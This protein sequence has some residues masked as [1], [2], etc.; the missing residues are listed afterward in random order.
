[1]KHGEYYNFF[2]V[3]EVVED[4]LKTVHSKFKP[5]ILKYFKG[6]LLSKIFR[7]KLLAIQR[8]F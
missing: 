3:E 4:F 2:S 7:H 5:T 8:R 1:M 6:I